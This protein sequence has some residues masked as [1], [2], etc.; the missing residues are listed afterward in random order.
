M[1]KSLL[2]PFNLPEKL[3]IDNISKA[4]HDLQID[5]IVR[6]VFVDVSKQKKMLDIFINTSILIA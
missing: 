6:N 5:D 3:D 2:N 1:S 4:I